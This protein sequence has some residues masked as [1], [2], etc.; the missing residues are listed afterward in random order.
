MVVLKTVEEVRRRKT[1]V[2]LTSTIVAALFAWSGFAW[3]F[4]R[5]GVP[6]ERALGV[7][8][9]H[10]SRRIL[11]EHATVDPD[12]PFR[13]VYVSAT[14]TTDDVA[15]IYASRASDADPDARRFELPN[16]TT[17]TILA[18]EDVPATRLMPIQP[19]AENPP[20]GTGCWIILSRG[21]P[22]AATWTT[23]VPP[24]LGES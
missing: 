24:D 11:E 23:A 14:G 19:V 12:A 7:A 17:V 22:P 6:V 8:L 13:A 2:L 18:P 3:W 10:G 20:L 9:P 15:A 5:A 1:A 4:A 21:T 16:G